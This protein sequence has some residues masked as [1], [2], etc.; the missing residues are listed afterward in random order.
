MSE[1]FLPFS[2]PSMNQ[3][4]IDEVTA[5]LKSGWITTGPR[6]KT[7]EQ[8]LAN[9]LN[10]P[11]TSALSSATAGLH[12]SLIAMNLQPGDEVITTPMTFVASLN[13]IALSGAKPILV[14]IDD[15][16]NMDV[17]LVEAAIT[18]DTKAIMPVHFTG[19]PVDLDPLYK[20]AEKYDLRILEDA[21][22]AMGT[23][24]KD[25]LIGSFGDTQVFSFHPNKNMTT[26][27][28]GC[29]STRDEVLS[30]R[31]NALRFH[32]IDRSAWDRYGK[33]GNQHYDIFEPGYKFNMMDIQAALG[34]HQLKSLEDFI[35]KRTQLAKRYLEICAN[36]KEI[37][38]PQLPTYQHR[39]SWHLF[40]IKI[41]PD[42]ADMDRD[43][44]MKKMMEK[45]IGTGLH[46]EP[47]HLF[48]Y[49]QK[50]GGFKK[51]DFPKAEDTGSRIVSLPLFPDMTI[52]EQDRVIHTMKEIFKQ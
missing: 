9:Y 52:A 49:Y 41:N 11:L 6:V 16:Y 8:D 2:K 28:G 36:W 7:F 40:A 24:Y 1:N 21:A 17:S 30:K 26:G 3:A 12:L 29:V 13:V 15:T 34:I 4:A 51:G 38:L 20:L 43:T 47:A 27:E 42:I 50:I 25:K 33:D 45:G 18:S 14:D 48:H 22:Q 37:T 23:H 44:F 31:M 32:G 10:T 39:H 19:L 35:Q 46:Y 5:C